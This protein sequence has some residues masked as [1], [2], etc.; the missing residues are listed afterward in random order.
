MRLQSA[1]TMKEFAGLDEFGRR[2]DED[3]RE[4]RRRRRRRRRRRMQRDMQKRRAQ[5]MRRRARE[6]DPKPR[7][8]KRRPAPEGSLVRATP[9]P[10]AAITEPE[11]IDAEYVDEGF[12]QGVHPWSPAVTMGPNLRIQA[13]AG[14]RAAVIELKPG[15]FVVAEVPEHVTR[16][17]FGVLPLLAPLVVSA[18]TKAITNPKPPEQRL[19]PKLVQAVQQKQ[20]A[21]PGASPAQPGQAQRLLTTRQPAAAPVSPA[22]QRQLVPAAGAG[23]GQTAL[24]PAPVLGRWVDEDDLAGLFGCDECGGRCGRHR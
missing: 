5:R 21:Q 18:A 10:E 3:E 24:M 12:V 17:E 20:A 22:P 16:S 11:I 19:L 9:R 14:Y 15:L 13:A 23:H 2:I 1:L 8:K 6:L 7:R 4:A